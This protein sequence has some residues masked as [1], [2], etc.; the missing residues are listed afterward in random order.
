MP[1]RTDDAKPARFDDLFLFF[2]GLFFIRSIKFL[3]AVADFCRFLVEFRITCGKFDLFVFD[4]LFAQPFFGEIF[5][6]AA[7]KNIGTAPR[8]VGGD[9]HRA[10]SARL[11]H[12]FR[13]AF[14][15][16][17]VQN[18]MLNAVTDQ[19]TGNFFRLVDR[20]RTHKNGLSF[21]VPFHDL[22]D[23]RLF[24]PFYGRKD[25]VVHILTA[26]GFI[27]GNFDDVERINSTEFAL[28]RLCGTRHTRKFTVKTEIVL[29]CDGC[30]RFVFFPYFHALFRFDC[31]VQSVGITAADH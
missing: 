3:I 22:A 10:Q 15:I 21:F 5:R 4:A 29:E 12:D 28:F 30:V 1:F 14:V 11:R 26:H 24:L 9:R 18:I 25:A 17:C 2:F 16:L 19:K 23:D 8:H 7:Q 31:L 6:V 27:G 20:N 13:F